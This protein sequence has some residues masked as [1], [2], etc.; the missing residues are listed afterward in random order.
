M[1]D[2]AIGLT[3]CARQGSGICVGSV[4]EGKYLIIRE[5]G[6][7]GMSVVWLAQDT[8]LGK[9]WAIKEIRPNV[10]G[11]QGA[12]MRQ[13]LIDEAQFMKRLDHHAI[14]RVTDILD[15]GRT[16]LV[17]M[18]YVNA[19]PLDRVMA[20]RGAP[21]PQD[22]VID[23][24]IQLCDVL[25]YLHGLRPPVVYRDMKPS[26]VLLNSNGTLSLIDFGIALELT[27]DALRRARRM[28]SVG[29]SAPEQLESR[30]SE[31]FVIDERADVYALGATLYSLVTGHVP[32]RRGD[33]GA[34]SVSF[35]MRP[36]REVD[37]RLSEGLERI[38][39][40]ATRAVPEERYATV[41][42]MRADLERYEELTSAWL[43]AQRA[44]LH[45]FRM[46]VLEAIVALGVG[47]ML[48]AARTAVRWTSYDSLMHDGALALAEALDGASGAGPS[49]ATGGDSASRAEAC[50]ARAVAVAP[51]RIE[52]YEQ[53]LETYKVDERFSP[54]EAGRWVSLW[55]Q[56]GHRARTSGRLARLCYDVGVLYLCYYDYANEGGQT[57][58]APEAMTGQ[59]AIESASRANVW[60]AAAL[61]A[62]DAETGSYQGLLVDG[63]HDEHAALLA[64]QVIASFHEQIARASREGAD[65][66]PTYGA[67]WKTVSAAIRDGGL[68]EQTEPIVQLRL[69]QVGFES[70]SSATYLKGFRQ[71]GVEQQ[72]AV[73]LLDAIMDR[74]GALRDFAGSN[75][76]ATGPI[77]REIDEGCEQAR[78]NIRTTFNGPTARLSETSGEGA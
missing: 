59:A 9:L 45:L 18:D 76:A 29:Y 3:S 64:Y 1:R 21:F 12:T 60:F 19:I 22:E 28:G 5:L 66:R 11:I 77:V 58:H 13:A 41:A 52:P 23:W 33:D 37:P 70:L 6:R 44:S 7:G 50:Y 72:E 27:P 10:T 30:G 56:F 61:D 62:C 78:L 67:F 4:I 32:R 69:L 68:I 48:L 34:A 15:T 53:L 40:K 43:A 42:D 31:P 36:I 16:T 17:V 25:S 71:A 73:T 39:A 74:L 24:G 14:P 35:A 2:A 54:A 65:P 20:E 38:L 46:R 55:R 75:E 47:L 63:Q 57:S 8:R 49:K 51:E 26:N